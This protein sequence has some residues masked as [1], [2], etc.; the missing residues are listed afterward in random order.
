MIILKFHPTLDNNLLDQMS[1]HIGNLRSVKYGLVL[2]KVNFLDWTVNCPVIFSLYCQWF[3]PG[4]PVSSTNKT[5]HQDI[6]E[7]LLK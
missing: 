4:T 7:V 2:Y 6:I 1:S 3:S 5:D